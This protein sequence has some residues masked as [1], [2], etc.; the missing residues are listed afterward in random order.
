MKIPATRQV[1]IALALLI[2]FSLLV[3]L[4]P[5][6]PKGGQPHPEKMSTEALLDRVVDRGDQ[7]ALLTLTHR[8]S[9]AEISDRLKAMTRRVK[10]LEPA[11]RLVLAPV[12]PDAA[13]KRVDPNC[14]TFDNAGTMHTVYTGWQETNKPGDQSE[15]NRPLGNLY[16]ARYADGKWSQSEKIASGRPDARD[17]KFLWDT[18]KTLYVLFS[19]SYFSPHPDIPEMDPWDED[20]LFSHLPASAAW[21][22]PENILTQ[23]PRLMHGYTACMDRNGA[24]HLL[25]GHWVSN[26]L[27]ET[28]RYRRWENGTWQKEEDLPVAGNRNMMNPIVRCAGD[29][30]L[31]FACGQ[32]PL[33]QGGIIGLYEI[34]RENGKWHDPRL[35]VDRTGSEFDVS[36]DEPPF[37][38]IAN[39]TRYRQRGEYSLF[40]A[41]EK[42]RAR[43]YC[44]MFLPGPTGQPGHDW[45]YARIINDDSGHPLIV[46]GECGNLYLLR[47]DPKSAT[48]AVCLS[49]GKTHRSSTWPVQVL[50]RGTKVGIL[51]EES[52]IKWQDSV[53]RYAEFEIPAGGW[54]PATDVLWRLR[55]GQGLPELHY[56]DLARK[57]FLE[58]KRY[59]TALDMQMA[60][61]RYIYLL[62][63]FGAGAGADELRDASGRLTELSEAGVNEVRIQLARYVQKNPE[64]FQQ[65]N[66]Q[67][68]QLRTVLHELG[69]KAEGDNL[70]ELLSL[71]TQDRK[72]IGVLLKAYEYEPFTVSLA[73]G[74]KL[75]I[76]PKRR[77]LDKGPIT[78]SCKDFRERCKLRLRW[79]RADTIGE[80]VIAEMTI[81]TFGGPQ[82]DVDFT[83]EHTLKEY[84]D[85]EFR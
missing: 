50:R 41:D 53:S 28:I 51:Y 32:Q 69:F 15:E 81:H 21:A 85:F 23:R 58:G 37:F 18:R 14:V 59:D 5:S 19:A 20:I 72:E 74:K 57:V 66:R 48:Q 3:L 76:K 26:G 8:L 17:A 68:W 25:W 82:G 16:Y 42:G 12:G 39:C 43:P 33:G 6:R 77:S 73:G 65:S 13:E 79:A 45:S 31:V 52:E 83:E 1:L 49:A 70:S 78:L 38:V 47:P 61:E 22:K 9:I 56:R 24:I 80:T 64:V 67:D 11:L 34:V 71:P 29:R 35:L 36:D 46:T 27:Q 84:A 62:S 75:W 10:S 2:T 60:V 54:E 4:L 7:D 30:L 40:R 55:A 63:Q 44:R